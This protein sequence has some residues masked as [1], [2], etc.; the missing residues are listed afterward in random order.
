MNGYMFEIILKIWW[1]VAILPFLIFI[2]G[3][4][5]F[6]DF[7]K[8]KNIYSY[9]DLWHSFLIVLIILVIILLMNGYR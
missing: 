4:K 8:K 9:W 2:E 3:S 6:A 7:L 1:M 5:K